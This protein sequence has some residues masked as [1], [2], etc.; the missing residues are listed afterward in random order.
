MLEQSYVGELDELDDEKNHSVLSGQGKKP[1][2]LQKATNAIKDMLSA[3]HIDLSA[4]GLAE[5]PRRAA[6]A[7]AEL[8]TPKAFKATTFPN[9]H[10]YDE[11]VLARSIPFHSVCEHHLLPFFGVAHVG[12]LPADRIIGLSKL[13][14]LVE[15]FSRRPQVQENLTSQISCW[16]QENLKPQGVGVI[17]EA[18][19]LCM[20]LRGVKAPGVKTITSCLTGLVRENPQ[21]RQEFLALANS[22]R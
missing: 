15:Y 14:R 4:E 18:E 10:H 22:S 7:Y 11:L 13:A 19:H 21:S 6:L 5:T 16:L 1:Y 3:F 17:L 20:S 8:F 2:D 9:T 12:Y